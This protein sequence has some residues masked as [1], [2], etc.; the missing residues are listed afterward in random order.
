MLNLWS[1]DDRLRIREV[2]ETFKSHRDV[3]RYLMSQLVGEV[4]MNITRLVLFSRLV[5]GSAYCCLKPGFNLHAPFVQEHLC[6]SF[7]LG[8][9]L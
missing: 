5:S 9:S 3:D 2:L 6:P 8:A 1:D 4:S 7:L